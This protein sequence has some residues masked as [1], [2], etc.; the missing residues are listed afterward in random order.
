MKLNLGA[1][2]VILPVTP[3][4]QYA[5]LAPMPDSCFEPG[6]VNV[7]KF[8]NDGITE[9]IDLFK[10]PWIRSSNGSPFSDSSIDEIY[11]SHLV[12]HI[13]HEVK[14]SNLIPMNWRKDYENLA[15]SFDGWFV[16]FYECWRILKPGGVL[17]VV[18]PFAASQAGMSD[19]THTRYIWP[20]TFSYFMPNPD[21]P[22]D[23]HLPY[24]FEA[25]NDVVMR[26]TE[27]GAEMARMGNDQLLKRAIST[28]I[29]MIDELRVTLKAIKK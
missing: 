29:N 26:Y 18:T 13:P 15:Q 4:T 28:K 16:F 17:N 14:V 20:A 11:C 8:Q 12:E 24:Q 6:W 22:F 1:G 5:H 27:H 7:D 25:E 9:V 23:Y 10:F 19:P 2:R 3:E 21:A